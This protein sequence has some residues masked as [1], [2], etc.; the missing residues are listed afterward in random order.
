MLVRYLLHQPHPQIGVLQVCTQRSYPNCQSH[1][2]QFVTIEIPL[3]SER[4]CVCVCVCN[5]DMQTQTKQ[6][7]LRNQ[8]LS[9]CK[10]SRKREHTDEES[11]RC[12]LTQTTV[13]TLQP[14][15]PRASLPQIRDSNI[16]SNPGPCCTRHVKSWV[17][18][19]PYLV[20]LSYSGTVYGSLT[21]AQIQAHSFLD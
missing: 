13:T 18:L 1:C 16:F 3:A 14:T 6:K 15:D 5:A 21:L 17:I 9:L 11:R 8:R 2:P 10:S 4:Q 20:V 19:L 7:T 12:L